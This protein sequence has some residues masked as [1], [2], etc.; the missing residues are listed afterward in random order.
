MVQISWDVSLRFLFN[1]L[2]ILEQKISAFIFK[3]CDR[4]TSF[5]V[6]K[7][8]MRQ[9]PLDRNLDIRRQGT[10]VQI[11]KHLL[12]QSRMYLNSFVSECNLTENEDFDS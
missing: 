5:C 3:G 10:L 11:L 2:R 7:L 12:L 8:L 6:S 9:N 1:V 4:P